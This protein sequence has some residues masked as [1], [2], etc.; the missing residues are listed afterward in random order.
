M[1]GRSCIIASY[2]RDRFVGK[3]VMSCLYGG[4]L[5]SE[6]QGEEGEGG[7]MGDRREDKRRL[8]VDWLKSTKR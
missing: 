5:K 8:I 4:R 6:R 3:V 7:G 1:G 2:K